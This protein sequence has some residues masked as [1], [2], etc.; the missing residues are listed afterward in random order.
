MRRRGKLSILRV[1]ND[2]R[3]IING[4]PDEVGRG[5]RDRRE[6]VEEVRLPRL[7]ARVEKLEPHT[8]EKR[9][10][11]PGRGRVV[12]VNHFPD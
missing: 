10:A 6:A 2:I 12:L 4:D 3:G 7:T 5:P 8:R 11:G 1:S 9:T